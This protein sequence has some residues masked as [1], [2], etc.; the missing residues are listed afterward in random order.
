M[1]SQRPPL[2]PSYALYARASL[3]LVFE[4]VTIML[5]TT[6]GVLVAAVLPFRPRY[7]LLRTWA[8]INIW[9]LAR[10]CKLDYQVEGLQ[11]CPSRPSIVMANH[12][13]AWETLAF[14]RFFPPMAWVLKRELLWIPLFGWGL[15]LIEPI[16]IDRKAGRRS[17]DRMIDVG[18]RRLRA[19]RWIMIFPQGTRLPPGEVGRLKIGGAMLATNTEAPIV[20]VVHNSGRY[21][22]RKRFVKYPGTIQVVIGPPIETEGRS[23]QEVLAEVRTWIEENLRRIDG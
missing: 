6:V 14:Q 15:A 3:Y 2:P 21:W 5:Y 4:V 16:A 13:S 9:F 23:A 22:G 7:R 17:L 19:G 10:V 18:R 8:E 1:S 11:N 20:P 12:Q